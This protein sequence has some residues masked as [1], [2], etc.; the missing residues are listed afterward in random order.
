[1]RKGPSMLRLVTE[2]ADV[3]QEMIPGTPLI[4]ITGSSRV[5]IENHCGV[6]IYEPDWIRIRVK[7][8]AVNLRGD[9][10][11]ISRMSKRQLVVTGRLQALEFERGSC[12]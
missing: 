5:L 4:E 10:L 11:T 9:G 6:T 8:G 12:G 2:A 1:M 7:L 3:P